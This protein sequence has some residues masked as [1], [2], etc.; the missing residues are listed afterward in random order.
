[1]S[2]TRYRTYQVFYNGMS[3]L[4]EA[5]SLLAAKQAGIRYFNPPKS[6]QHLVTP[7]LMDE[8]IHV[9]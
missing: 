3:R 9:D 8:L 1:M 7:V 4:M 2:E 5:S 6:K